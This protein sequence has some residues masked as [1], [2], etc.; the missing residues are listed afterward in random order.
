MELTEFENYTW[1]KIRDFK[2]MYTESD[3][4]SD[5][6]EYIADHYQEESDSVV[7]FALIAD[8]LNL[9][10]NAHIN[11]DEISRE[12]FA[13]RMSM[14]ALLLTDYE[15]DEISEIMDNEKVEMIFRNVRDVVKST[16]LYKD[17]EENE[18]VISPNNLCLEKVLKEVGC[19]EMLAEYYKI[20][21]AFCI[22]VAYSADTENQTLVDWIGDLESMYEDVVSDYDLEAT[23]L[24]IAID[25]AG[26]IVDVILE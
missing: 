16:R 20:L 26:Y 21:N 7:D 22:Y 14:Y 12:T 24:P 4:L 18:E 13:L 23:E 1:K 6:R 11:V 10:N 9:M 25:E 3:K 2:E 5:I 15:K 19:H 17:F 8:M